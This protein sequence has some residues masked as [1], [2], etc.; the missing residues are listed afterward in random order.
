MKLIEIFKDYIRGFEHDS[1]AEMPFGYTIESIQM[2][3][4]INRDLSMIVIF[5]FFAI[6]WLGMENYMDI[7]QHII[8]FS[9]QRRNFL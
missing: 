1:R 2:E 7:V 8:D 6:F 3:S 5:I 9:R 4:E